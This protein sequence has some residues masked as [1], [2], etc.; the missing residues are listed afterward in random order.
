M[1]RVES[2]ETY[3]DLFL[4]HVAEISEDATLSDRLIGFIN[5]NNL[6][7][8]RLEKIGNVFSN[9]INVS[10]KRV[11]YLPSVYEQKNVAIPPEE[12][13]HHACIYADLATI[14][15]IAAQ[16]PEL[17]DLLAGSPQLSKLMIAARYAPVAVVQF[18]LEN[19]ADAS[20]TDSDGWDALHHACQAGSLE[21]AE[22]LAFEKSLNATTTDGATPL[23]LAAG[24]GHFAVVQ[25]LLKGGADTSIKNAN[26]VNALH[27]A[28]QGGSLEAVQLLILKIDP[29]TI[30]ARG[31]PLM[32]SVYCEHLAI[33]EFLLEEGADPALT[34]TNGWNVLHHACLSGSLE[35]A[36]LLASHID[37]NVTMTGG[38]TSLMAAAQNGHQAIVQFLLG[39][40]AD[41]STKDSAGCNAL[42]FAC[43]GGSLETV[44]VLTSHIDLKATTTSSQTP[45]ML[46]AQNGHFTVIQF[47]LEKG[48][49]TSITDSNGWNALHIACEAGSLEAAELLT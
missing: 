25:F 22:L 21:A 3:I 14:K 7:E 41:A 47:L 30:G 13:L 18:L 24:N 35:T 17:L 19:G 8:D 5:T 33:V 6:E 44:Q 29:N 38:Q 1:E 32:V 2:P 34:D 48:A 43:I 15:K 39:K 40:G 27:S 49:E 26:G 31:T 42:H 11:Y 45:L 37:L 12:R 20:I 28:C 9:L 10:G 23:M 46:A 16:S 36:E 4:A